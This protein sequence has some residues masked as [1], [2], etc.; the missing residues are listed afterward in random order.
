MFSRYLCEVYWIDELIYKKS[1]KS[2][3]NAIKAMSGFDSE[4][5]IEITDLVFDKVIPNHEVRN[6]IHELCSEFEEF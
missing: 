6:Y 1:F 5:H 3:N 2:I 4:C